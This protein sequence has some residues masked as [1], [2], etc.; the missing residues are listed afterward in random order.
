MCRSCSGRHDPLLQ[1]DP[2][3]IDDRCRCAEGVLQYRVKSGRLVVTKFPGNPYAGRFKMEGD[4][5]DERD[6][7]AYV[8]L[9]RERFDD[10]NFD[11]VRYSDGSSTYDMAQRAR[12]G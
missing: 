1:R 2:Y 7:N 12:V 5:T 3:D 9:G 10:E 8:K 11:P 4:T 6:W